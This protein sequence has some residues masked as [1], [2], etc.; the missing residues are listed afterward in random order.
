[1][2]PKLR[3][4]FIP[5]Q[6]V[7]MAKDMSKN[8]HRFSVLSIIAVSVFSIAVILAIGVFIYQRSLV[9]DINTMNAKLVSAKTAFEPGFIDELVK[10]DRRISAAE[11]VLSS[12]TVTT[13]IFGLLENETIQ[14]VSFSDFSY[15]LDAKKQPSISMKGQAVNFLAIAS[16]SDVFSSDKKIINPLFSELN[17]DDKGTANFAFKSSLDSLSFLYK[18]VF[19]NVASST[20]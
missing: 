20:P 3:T 13:P 10:L 4:S 18:S 19:N 9:R 16:Q 17:L 1:M 11:E 6:E 5:K 15:I 8:A 2:D 12:H 7:I 14:G